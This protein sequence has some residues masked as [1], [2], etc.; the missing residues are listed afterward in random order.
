MPVVAVEVL[1]KELETR[2]KLPM[3]LS[4]DRNGRG[5]GGQGPKARLGGEEDRRSPARVSRKFFNCALPLV[6]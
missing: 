3:L 6:L 5:A 4:A 1:T 2:A